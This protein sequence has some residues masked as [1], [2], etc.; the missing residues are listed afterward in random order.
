MGMIFVIGIGLVAGL[1]LG[2]FLILAFPSG[3]GG[4]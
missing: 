1:I 3:L 2:A 4:S